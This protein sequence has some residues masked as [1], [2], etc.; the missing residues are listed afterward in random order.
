MKGQNLL[1]SMASALNHVNQPVFLLTHQD[2]FCIAYLRRSEPHIWHLGK[3][4]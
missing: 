1:R 3:E 2:Y 4:Y